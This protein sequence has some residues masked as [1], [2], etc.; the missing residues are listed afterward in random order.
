M[1]IEGDSKKLI[2]SSLKSLYDWISGGGKKKK[3]LN[4]VF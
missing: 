4:Y 1:E 3:K 2:S